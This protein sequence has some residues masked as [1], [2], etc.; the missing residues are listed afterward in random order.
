MSTPLDLDELSTEPY[1]VALAAC[2]W[3]EF[4]ITDNGQ[5]IYAHHRD[6][7]GIGLART[8]VGVALYQP[9]M[10]I[11]LTIVYFIGTAAT[12]S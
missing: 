6:Y 3:N 9:T 12:P 11:L 10:A 5:G 7:C 8:W 1:G 4:M 2:L